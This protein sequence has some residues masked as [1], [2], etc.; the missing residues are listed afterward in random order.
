MAGIF[1]YKHPIQ[2]ISFHDVSSLNGKNGIP[3]TKKSGIM[4]GDKSQ[5]T[6]I[7]NKRDN[8][9]VNESQSKKDLPKKVSFD[10]TVY[11]QALSRTRAGGY[12]PPPKSNG[13][14]GLPPMVSRAPPKPKNTDPTAVINNSLA[15]LRS[16][17]CEAYK[18]MSHKPSDMK[19]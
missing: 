6:I 13:K 14:G 1:K 12:V 11:S 15:K 3:I 9:L 17:G 18:C 16:N 5:S 7:D 19:Q 8:A 2:P 4:F 10:R